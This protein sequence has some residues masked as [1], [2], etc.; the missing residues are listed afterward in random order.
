M[1]MIAHMATLRRGRCRSCTSS[2]DSEPATS[3]RRSRSSRTRTSGADRRGLGPRAPEGRRL[4]PDRPNLRGTAQNPDVFFQ[5]REACNPFYLAVPGIVRESMERF[6]KL[7]GVAYGLVRLRLGAPDAECVLVHDGIGR[8]AP[9][10]QAVAKL[11]ARGREGRPPDGAPVPA[12]R[13]RGL[14]GSAAEDGAR[15]RRARPH[16]GAGGDRRAAVPGRGHRARRGVAR[17]GRDAAGD[18]RPL[19]T[20]VGRSSRRR[21]PRRRSTRS[22]SRSRSATSPSAST[23]RTCRSRSTMRSTLSRR[24]SR[25]A[26]TASVPTAPSA[27]PRTR[28]RSSARTRRSTCRA[29]SSTTASKSGAITVSHL[30]FG[31]KP[32]ES[33]YLIRHADFIACHQFEFM[34]SSTCWC[35]PGPAQRSCSTAPTG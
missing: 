32:I 31:P 33:S 29:T 22:R 17:A 9:R 15:D 1:A 24:A 5:A 2:T 27:R 30:R 28:S 10:T 20:V 34:R 35:L 18:R 14:R 21:W 25:A 7:T 13:H 26:S 23:S 3:S 12:V 4:H 19:R 16:Q 8:R 11:V 6:A